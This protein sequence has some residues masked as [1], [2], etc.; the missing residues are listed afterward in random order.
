MPWGK[1]IACVSPPPQTWLVPELPAVVNALRSCPRPRRSGHGNAYA[2]RTTR[3]A[4]TSCPRKKAKTGSRQFWAIQRVAP[5][6]LVAPC[7][8]HA[9]LARIGGVPLQRADPTTAGICIE[10]TVK[11]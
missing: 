5:A 8:A 9:A 6:R 11:R 1:H 10:I 3:S 2:G 4:L 7:A